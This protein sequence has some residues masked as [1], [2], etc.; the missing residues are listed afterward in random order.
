[1][2]ELEWKETCNKASAMLKAIQ[3]AEKVFNEEVSG[4]ERTTS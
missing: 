1:V 4:D 3:L 2:P